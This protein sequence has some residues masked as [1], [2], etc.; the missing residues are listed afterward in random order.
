MIAI[1]EAWFEEVGGPPIGNKC[2]DVCNAARPMTHTECT[3]CCGAT[4]TRLSHKPLKVV[5]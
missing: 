3:L 1:R 4:S 5:A 2:E